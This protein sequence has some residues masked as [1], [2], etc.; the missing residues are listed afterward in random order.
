MYC[1]LTESIIHVSEKEKKNIYL[2]SQL[3]KI[4]IHSSMAPDPTT[5]G[6]KGTWSFCSCFV[7]FQLSFDFT[8]FLLSLHVIQSFRAKITQLISAWLTQKKKL[9]VC[10]RKV[11]KA[12]H[13]ISLRVHKNIRNITKGLLECPIKPALIKEGFVFE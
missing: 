10:Q 3:R 12:K 8:H 9:C 1:I 7:F 5:N 13:V 6:F 4:Y 2:T 11:D